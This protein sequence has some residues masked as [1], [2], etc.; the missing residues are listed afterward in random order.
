M[1]AGAPKMSSSSALKAAT[2]GELGRLCDEAAGRDTVDGFPPLI[3]TRPAVV[4]AGDG[5][6]R[7]NM[8]SSSGLVA[9]AGGEVAGR[10]KEEDAAD[11]DTGVDDARDG[12]ADVEGEL[13]ADEEVDSAPKISSSSVLGTTMAGDETTG[14]GGTLTAATAL[15]GAVSPCMVS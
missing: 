2:G 3:D 15:T 7:P 14:C 5:T 9:A 6:G 12:A 1:L 8:S 10:E 4:E 11:A 13:E